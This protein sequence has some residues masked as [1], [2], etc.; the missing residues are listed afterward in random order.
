MSA[1]TRLAPVVGASAS[2]LLAVVLVITF[3]SFV[4]PL[5]I[6]AT[7]PLAVI[8]ARLG[9]ADR[10]QA[11]LHALVHG[12]D[13]ADGHRGGRT[14]SFWS[15]S[16]RKPWPEGFPLKDAILQAV[17]LRTRPHPDDRHRRG[18]GHGFRSPL[19]MG[20]WGWSACRRW[21]VIAIGGLFA[22]TFPGRC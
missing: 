12:P 15:I 4:S 7:L 18:G 13:P 2:S 17:E 9:H 19:E 8:G 6:L 22:G 5:A 16:P 3:R 14:A 20:R 10:R 11:W 1:F 21:A